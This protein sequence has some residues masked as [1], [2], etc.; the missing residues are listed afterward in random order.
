MAL[1]STHREYHLHPHLLPL[2]SSKAKGPYHQS[3]GIYGTS[4]QRL[5]FSDI[6]VFALK[7]PL[8]LA[9]STE[10]DHHLG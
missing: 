7:D 2:H 5:V 1:K 10:Y 6:W 3:M 8:V 4:T 9:S